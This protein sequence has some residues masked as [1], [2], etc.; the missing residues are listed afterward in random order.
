TPRPSIALELN[1]VAV[2]DA[3]WTEQLA[4][5]FQAG[6]A[7]LN[8]DYRAALG[9][10]PAAMLPIVEFYARGEG[11]FKADAGRIKQRRIAQRPAARRAPRLPMRRGRSRSEAWWSGGDPSAPP[12][13][14]GRAAGPHPWVPPAGPR[15]CAA[16]AAHATARPSAWRNAAARARRRSRPPRAA[17]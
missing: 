7:D 6:L 15:A 4:V 11:P 16:T 5:Q 10:F 3:A 1:G 2:D 9:E 8:L 12:S 13:C 17:P 14:R